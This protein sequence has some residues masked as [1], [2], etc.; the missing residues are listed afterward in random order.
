M[1]GDDQ[2]AE[3]GAGIID[4]ARY[5]CFPFRGAVREGSDIDDRDCVHLLNSLAPIS[6]RLDVIGPA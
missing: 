4:R 1:S 5:R 3:R 6:H 2:K